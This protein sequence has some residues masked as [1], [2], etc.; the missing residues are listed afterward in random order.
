MHKLLILISFLVIG[1]YYSKAQEDSTSAQLEIFECYD[2]YSLKD[3][4]AQVVGLVSIIPHDNPI[5]T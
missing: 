2:R 5:E 3:Q 1:A 4:W